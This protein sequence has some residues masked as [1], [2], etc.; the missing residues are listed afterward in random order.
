MNK[1]LALL[2]FYSIGAL[3]IFI[4]NKISP[5]AHDGGPGFG[6]LAFLLFCIII[7]LLIIY[8]TYKGF[9]ADPGYFIIA[10]I[11]LAILLFILFKFFI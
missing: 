6:T 9:S 7:I 10:G 4:L 1:Y 3:V 2:L 5:P 8:N 11:H